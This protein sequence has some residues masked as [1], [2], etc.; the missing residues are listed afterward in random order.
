MIP[1]EQYQLGEIGRVLMGECEFAQRSDPLVLK[2]ACAC[3]I[4]VCLDIGDVSVC[5]T[6][7]GTVSMGSLAECVP[8]RESAKAARRIYAEK[9]QQ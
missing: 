9:E 5:G 7:Y 1:S 3:R 2:R 8:F 6:V 4:C